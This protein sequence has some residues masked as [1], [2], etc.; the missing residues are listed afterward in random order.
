MND[1][2]E[3][4]RIKID[5]I[6]PNDWNPNVIEPNKFEI[7]TRN[8]KKVGFMLQPILVRKVDDHFQIIDGFHR[9]KASEKAGLKEI[10]CIII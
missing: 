9:W 8:I 3:I 10:D 4:K 6:K 5:N 2:Y 1:K 7:L